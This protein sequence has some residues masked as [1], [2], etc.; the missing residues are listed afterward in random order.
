MQLRV[1][2][3]DANQY[4]VRKA[5]A[6]RDESALD[7]IHRCEVPL[8]ARLEVDVVQP[9]VL[10]AVLVADVQEVA[11]VVGP[12]VALDPT[13]RVVGDRLLVVRSDVSDEHV[14]HAVQRRDVGKPRAIR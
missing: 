13:L 14:E 10:A 9:K 5:L 1:V 4:V 8:G 6:V 11:V 2:L 3:V 12:Q 7:A